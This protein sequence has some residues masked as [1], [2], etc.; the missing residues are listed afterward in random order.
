MAEECLKVQRL[1]RKERRERAFPRAVLAEQPRKTRLERKIGVG[2]FAELHD[3][4]GNQFHRSLLSRFSR[5][6]VPTRRAAR[7]PGSRSWFLREDPFRQAGAEIR[8][9]TRV[10]PGSTRNRARGSY[11]P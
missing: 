4:T 11:D 6:I 1:Y 3:M 9:A 5:A 7:S 8:R 10:R 2:E